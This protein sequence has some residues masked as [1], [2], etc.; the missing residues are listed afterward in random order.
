MPPA[1]ACDRCHSVKARCLAGTVRCCYRCYRLGHSC[2]YSRPRGKRGRKPRVATPCS[3]AF[4]AAK[5]D[6]YQP[7]SVLQSSTILP[8]ADPAHDEDDPQMQ[9]LP[10][11][12]TLYREGVISQITEYTSIQI[13]NFFSFGP[14]LSQ[15][16]C[17]MIR[18][19]LQEAPALLLSPYAA[20]A[21]VFLRSIANT[22]A[23]HD[24][25]LSHC[26]SALQDLRRAVITKS[27]Y[28]CTFLS[29]GT[30][31]LTFHRLISGVSASTICRHTLSL[32]R[33]FYYAGKLQGL[34]TRELVCLIF[35]DTT[36]SLFRARI[37]VIQLQE[38]D[39]S[40]VNQHAGLCGSLLP[41]LYRVCVLAS[42]VRTGDEKDISHSAT[43]DTLSKE[44]QEWSPII[45]QSVLERF[46]PDEMFLLIAQT[47]LHQNAA[48]LI[49]HRL[50]YPFGEQDTEAEAL[51]SSI[52]D[53]MTHCLDV[54]GKY[55]PNI[56][57]VLLVAGSEVHEEDKRQEIRS[58][59]LKIH[60]AH[61][62]PF[63]DNLLMSLCRVWKARDQGTARYL[64]S[65]FEN[66]PDLSI[67]L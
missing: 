18:S 14:L 5:K 30:S 42:E 13:C 22:T 50:R 46:S 58:L 60:G 47:N 62:Y 2:T 12:S 15:E 9:K 37:P 23:C 67:P 38:Q 32:I 45:P 55:P 59:V 35:L 31:L 3:L 19:R 24:A 39:P 7:E 44:L 4:D 56:T 34:D 52:V 49:L 29:L 26:A 25:D 33:P 41:L 48:L 43:Y 65:L 21:R 17:H 61:F 10:L 51:S 63:I 53:C 28:A 20:V 16:M 66:N 6:N 8:G 1:L 36:Q 64:F 40:V 57:L 27:D 54:A 11:V